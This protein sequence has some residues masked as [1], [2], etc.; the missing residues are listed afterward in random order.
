MEKEDLFADH[1]N[2]LAGKA[3]EG[4]MIMEEIQQDQGNVWIWETNDRDY[5]DR[6]TN[7]PFSQGSEIIILDIRG[8]LWCIPRISPLL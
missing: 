4:Q 2:G 7:D 5:Y 3:K 8:V 6:G 1:H